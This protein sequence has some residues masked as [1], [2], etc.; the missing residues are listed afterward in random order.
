MAKKI[1]EE[2]ASTLSVVRD[3][4]QPNNAEINT[5]WVKE[6]TILELKEDLEFAKTENQEQTTNVNGWLALRNTTDAES[7]NKTSTAGRSKVQPKLI[8]KH[9]EWRY[10]SLSEP[11]L[12]SD[13]MFTVE[14]RTYED[15]AGADQNQILINWQFDTKLDKVNFI[16]RVV[17]TVVDEGTCVLRVGWVREIEK[18]KVK[19]PVYEFYPLSDEQGLQLLG[20]AVQLLQSNDSQYEILPDSLKASAEY[21]VET[22]IPVVAK[23]T[24]K[25]TEV[26]E[27]IIVTNQPE[28]SIVDVRNYFIDSACRGIW[29]NA[30]Y[31]IYTYETTKSALKKRQIYKNLDKVNW[32]ANR[33]QS[34][35]GNPDYTSTSPMNDNRTNTDKSKVLV[36]EY[37]GLYDIHDNGIMSPIVVTWIGDTIIQMEE[38][39]FPDRKPPFVIIP[40]MPILNSTFGEADASLLQDNQRILG[41]VSRGMIDLLGRSANAQTGFAKGFLDLTNRKRYSSGEDFEFNPNGDPKQQIQ[42]MKYPEIPNSALQISMSQNLEAEALS[43]IKSFTTGISGDSYG[44]VA[45]GI[46]SATDAAGQR[47][48]SILRRLAEGIRLL[49]I[50]IISMNQVYLEEKEIVRVTNDRFVEIRRSDL[51]GNYDLKVDIS[52][53]SV[54]EAKAQ[55]L[56]FMLQTQGPNM[57]PGLLNVILAEIAELKRMPHLA[58]RIKNYKPEPDPLAE[59]AREL[60]LAKMEAEIVFYRARAEEMMAKANN[61]NLDTELDASGIKHNRAVEN[62]GAQARGNRNLEVTKKLLEDTSGMGD[63]R[64]AIGYNE[65]L[66]MKENAKKNTSPPLPPQPEINPMMQEELIDPN[67]LTINQ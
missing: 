65:L 43:G 21:F 5:G 40:Y 56:G 4:N 34:K 9:N 59:K 8:R 36:Y 22:G 25:F 63:I 37:W 38:N 54:D 11:F 49:G 27:D 26:E 53:Q 6:P 1:K 33:V 2:N 23:L 66:D 61:I 64:A 42:Q 35:I 39:P 62:A 52:T 30:Q 45:R 18:V 32:E 7:G 60:E 29:Q 24:N 14:P 31:Q 55:D 46:A 58:Y 12:N 44:K 67:Q 16:D 50:K 57:D 20:Q 17:R 51:V 3:E 28:I 10:P 15:K 19:K 13:R 48:M 41:A 47:E